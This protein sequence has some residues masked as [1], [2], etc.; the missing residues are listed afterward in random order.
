MR[1]VTII[2]PADSKTGHMSKVLTKAMANGQYSTSTFIQDSNG[3]FDRA[4]NKWYDT[5]SKAM[6]DHIRLIDDIS[7]NLDNKPE[8]VF[9]GNL[10]CIGN[11]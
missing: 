7:T 9:A 8:S 10:K 3:M 2:E 5:Y 4:S 11:K 1:I 6:L